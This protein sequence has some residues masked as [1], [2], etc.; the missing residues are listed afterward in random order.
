MHVHRHKDTHTPNK[1]HV[2]V[3]GG[4]V[5]ALLLGGG[6]SKAHGENGEGQGQQPPQDEQ[7]GPQGEPGAGIGAQLSDTHRA[8]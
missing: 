2:E 5:E 7:D 6:E 4:H 8:T 1:E 3:S